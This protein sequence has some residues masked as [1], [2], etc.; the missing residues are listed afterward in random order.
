MKMEKRCDNCLWSK[1]SS[2]EGMLLCRKSIK[3][4]KK[5]H[6]VRYLLCSY[7]NKCRKWESAEIE[8]NEAETN[9]KG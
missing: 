1:E 5:Y 6:S 3:M 8:E 4:I 9:Q 2:K 7:D